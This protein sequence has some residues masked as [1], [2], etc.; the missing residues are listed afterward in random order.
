MTGEGRWDVKKRDDKGKRSE[1][2]VEMMKG[3]GHYIMR[4]RKRKK[5]YRW[6]QIVSMMNSLRW[7][8][9]S[10]EWRGK[11]EAQRY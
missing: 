9:M 7:W 8:S 2:K 10:I 3:G 11:K 6:N 4:K 5:E 1:S